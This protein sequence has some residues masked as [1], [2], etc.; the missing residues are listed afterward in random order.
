MSSSQNHQRATNT[1]SRHPNFKDLPAGHP[2]EDALD[3]YRICAQRGDHVENGYQ[4]LRHTYQGFAEHIRRD[5]TKDSM[6]RFIAYCVLDGR[7]TNAESKKVRTAYLSEHREADNLLKTISRRAQLNKVDGI[8]GL[9]I[10]VE[11][12]L[13]IAEKNQELLEEAIRRMAEQD[14]TRTETIRLNSHRADLEKSLLEKA[15][16]M[17]TVFNDTFDALAEG[18]SLAIS[19]R[20]SLR[21]FAN[22]SP[23]HQTHDRESYGCN[24]KHDNQGRSQSPDKSGRREDNAASEA[25]WGERARA[26]FWTREAHGQRANGTGSRPSKSSREYPRGTSTHESQKQANA[27]SENARAGL[28]AKKHEEADTGHGSEQR[29][30]AHQHGRARRSY[31]DEY[32]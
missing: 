4:T 10:A 18:N 17:T 9:I 11:D 15:I 29:K 16:L 1:Q 3:K 23:N 32:L 19:L 21:K 31:E 13:E 25:R 7:E 14:R 22:K 12:S 28:W 6:N 5:V 26:H 27:R 24:R 2:L 20:G 30:D 8:D